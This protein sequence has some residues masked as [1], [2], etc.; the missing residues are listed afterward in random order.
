MREQ[1]SRVQTVLIT[2]AS[3]ASGASSPCSLRSMATTWRW[4]RAIARNCW[5][6]GRSCTR[7]TEWASPCS[8]TSSGVLTRLARAWQAQAEDDTAS[9]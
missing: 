4:C 5:R 9:A 2:G 8:P 6:W 3:G 7:G 1:E